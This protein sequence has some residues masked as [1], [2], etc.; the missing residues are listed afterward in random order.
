MKKKERQKLQTQGSVT[1]KIASFLNERRKS[2][3]IPPA[4][5]AEKFFG[6]HSVYRE[7][8]VRRIFYGQKNVSL[9]EIFTILKILNITSDDLEKIYKKLPEEEV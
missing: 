2:L 7:W 4:Y 9:G 8:C 6:D 1:L 3:K 5:V